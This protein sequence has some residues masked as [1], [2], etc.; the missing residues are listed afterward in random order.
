MKELT[1]EIS[2]ILHLGLKESDEIL[3][4]KK[5]VKLPVLPKIEI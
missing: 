4:H 2:I 1:S 5:Y 3:D